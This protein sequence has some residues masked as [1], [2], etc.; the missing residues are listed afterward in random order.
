M[1][2]LSKLKALE[3]PTKEIDVE[4]LG[5]KQTTVVQSLPDHVA[6]KIMSMQ[7]LNGTNPELTSMVIREILLTGAKELTPEDVDL[8][9][10]HDFAAAAKIAAA[11]RD[12]TA[13]HRKAMDEQRET[14]RKNSQ[15]ADMESVK[16]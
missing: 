1:I 8:L 5:E 14:A 15:T 10:V 3:L 9:V 13:Q 11:I 12:L 6:V 7:E 16:P 4:V 2:D